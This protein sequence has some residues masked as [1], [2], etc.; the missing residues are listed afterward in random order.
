MLKSETNQALIEACKAWDLTKADVL[1]ILLKSKRITSYEK[2]SQFY[3]L[4]CEITGTLMRNDTIFNYSVNAAATSMLFFK[5]VIYYYGCKD[6]LCNK[7]F[8]LNPDSE[9]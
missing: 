8:L 3:Y 2:N 7:F 4:P 6:T 5:D 1:T 9:E